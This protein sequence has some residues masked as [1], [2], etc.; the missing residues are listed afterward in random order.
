MMLT[1]KTAA[2][3]GIKSRVDPRESIEGGARYLALLHEKIG[4]GV[5]EPD[6][7][8]MALAAYNVGWGHLEDARALA[9]RLDKNPDSWQDVSTTLPLLRQKKYY[10]ALPHGY[11]RGTEPVRYVNRIKT[12]YRVLIQATEE[13]PKN[14]RQLA[15]IAKSLRGQGPSM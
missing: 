13:V 4:N 15:E 2:S 9:E 12:Y 5:S 14:D 3:L 11:A 6:R 1:Q 8:Y 10:R 7:M